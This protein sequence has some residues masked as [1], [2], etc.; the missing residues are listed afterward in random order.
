M[1]HFT[2]E[3]GFE[4]VRENLGASCLLWAFACEE[5]FLSRKQEA[6]LSYRDF[7]QFLEEKL[8]LHG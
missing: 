8:H 2:F 5:F 7:N 3:K 1:K 6:S 4:H